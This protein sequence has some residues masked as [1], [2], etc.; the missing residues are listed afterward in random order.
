MHRMLEF[1]ERLLIQV[2]GSGISTNLG[3]P[4]ESLRH[5]REVVAF[6]CLQMTQRIL[7]SRAICS[8]DIPRRSRLCRRSLPS[9]MLSSAFVV[10]G[11]S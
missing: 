8:S 10:A 9:A 1:C 3:A 2:N 4:V 5:D 6:Q 11:V 7:V